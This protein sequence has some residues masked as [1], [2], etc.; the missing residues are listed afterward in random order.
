[1]KYHYCLKNFDHGYEDDRRYM[2]LALYKDG[3]LLSI[4]KVKEAPECDFFDFC[5]D[6]RLGNYFAFDVLADA[7]D[8]DT[9]FN[10]ID[11]FCFQTCW[12]APGIPQIIDGEAYTNLVHE[13]EK[14]SVQRNKSDKMNLDFWVDLGDYTFWDDEGLRRFAKCFR[15]GA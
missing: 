14:H 2:M 12:D 11:D 5:Q 3:E 6:I 4:E 13:I 1:M 15:P 10:L 7:F 9:A 8:E